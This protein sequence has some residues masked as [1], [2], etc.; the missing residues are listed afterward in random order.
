MRIMVCLVYLKQQRVVIYI[1]GMEGKCKHPDAV[2]PSPTHSRVMW[3]GNQ[4]IPKEMRTH[5]RAIVR[6]TAPNEWKI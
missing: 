4:G 2:L 1:L 5:R 3:K 6:G